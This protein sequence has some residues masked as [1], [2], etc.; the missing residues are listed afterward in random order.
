MSRALKRTGDTS[1]DL[2]ISPKKR[3]RSEQPNFD[4]LNQCVFFGETCDVTKDSKHPERLRP[5]YVCRTAGDGDLKPAILKTCS[6][7]NIN[8]ADQVRLRV[9]GAIS[10][11]HAEDARYHVNCKSS[12]MSPKNVNT[13]NTSV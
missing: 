9:Q 7:R 4:F 12:F 6:L 1:T 8:W 2:N 11:L 3:R 5:A 13:A 10:D